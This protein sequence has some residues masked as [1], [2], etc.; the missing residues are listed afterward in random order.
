LPAPACGCETWYLT[1]REKHELQ[2]PENKLFREVFWSTKEKERAQ[3]KILH[4]ENFCGLNRSPYFVIIVKFRM[5]RWAGHVTRTS[6]TMFVEKL[7]GKRLL[8]RPRRGVEGEWDW[9]SCVIVRFA[10]SSVKLSDYGNI[11]LVV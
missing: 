2:A 7:L 8:G 6:K 1:L 9:G 3:F 5:L 4:S 10:M 11:M